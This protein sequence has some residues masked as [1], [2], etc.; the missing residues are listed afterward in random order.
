MKTHVK[1]RKNKNDNIDK[2]EVQNI[3]FWRK[4]NIQ[5]C[6]ETTKFDFCG[7]FGESIISN[8][9]SQSKFQVKEKKIIQIGLE[10][11]KLD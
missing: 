5:I 10:T 11:T 9:E 6:P 8:L 7:P 1:I 3:G 2:N 4:K